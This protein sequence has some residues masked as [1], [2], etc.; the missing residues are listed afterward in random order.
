VIKSL[1]RVFIY[2][3]YFTLI[4]LAVV[5]VAS[6]AWELKTEHDLNLMSKECKACLMDFASCMELADNTD[7]EDDGPDGFVHMQQRC[8]QIAEYCGKQNQCKTR[9]ERDGK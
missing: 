4:A 3:V 8:V 7:H 6:H 5:A 2:A 1:E 9:V